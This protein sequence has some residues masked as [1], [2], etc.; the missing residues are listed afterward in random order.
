MDQLAKKLD[1]SRSKE[2]SRMKKQ[3]KSSLRGML[4]SS[5]GC[6]VS[7]FGS[8]HESHSNQQLADPYIIANVAKCSHRTPLEEWVPEFMLSP[9]IIISHLL[10]LQQNDAYPSFQIRFQK[11]LEEVPLI[12]SSTRI[13]W[14][15]LPSDCDYDAKQDVY[16]D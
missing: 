10:P 1:K 3:A 9:V 2:I 5:L 14:I 7:C 11:F 12:P 8:P 6:I 16:V 4:E 15:L 13:S